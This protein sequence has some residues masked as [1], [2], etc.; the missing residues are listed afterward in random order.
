M[1]Q[2][3]TM[4]LRKSTRE[5]L[6]KRQVQF[7][8]KHPHS[9][10]YLSLRITSLNEELEAVRRLRENDVAA[11]KGEKAVLTDATRRLNKEVSDAKRELKNAIEKGLAAERT[12]AETQLVSLHFPQHCFPG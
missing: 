2:R 10:T 1:R 12:K 7:Y 3:S 6:H 5:D 11:L 4:D 9:L 8:E